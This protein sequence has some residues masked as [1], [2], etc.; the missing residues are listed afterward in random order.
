M[1]F[2]SIILK[3]EKKPNQKPQ[4]RLEIVKP[5]IF[6]CPIKYKKTVVSSTNSDGKEKKEKEKSWN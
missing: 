2:F 5:L 6:L 3:E 1:F 4:H